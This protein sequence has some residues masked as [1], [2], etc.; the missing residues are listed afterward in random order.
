[1][2]TIKTRILVAVD[3]KG[4]WT[5]AGYHN[6]P[7]PR[8]WIALDDLTECVAFHW[9]EAEIPIPVPQTFTGT[10]SNDQTPEAK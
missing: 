4:V 7:D 6:N 5:A 2:Q 1:M 8:E 3:E 10:V 9:V